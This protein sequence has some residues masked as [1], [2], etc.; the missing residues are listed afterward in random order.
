M[1]PS[2]WIYILTNGR[3]TT[4][5]VGCTNDLPTRLWEHRSK[6][7][8]K[9]FTARYNVSKLVYYESFE[10]IAEA[11]AREKFIKGKSRKW[12]ESLINGMNPE[13]RDLTDEIMQ[14]YR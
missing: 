13:W 14:R 7:N 1:P 5:Y 8:H 12:K 11:V 10:L 9:S 4:L 3:H 6:Q 2:A